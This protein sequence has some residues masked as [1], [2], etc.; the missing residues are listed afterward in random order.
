MV[1]PAAAAK[2]IKETRLAQVL[3]TLHQQALT[4]PQSLSVTEVTPAV[5]ADSQPQLLAQTPSREQVDQLQEQLQNLE[6]T[7]EFGNIYEGSPAITLSNPSGFG[8]DDFTGFVGFGYQERTRFG[9]KDDGT[10]GVG[11]GLGDAE[12]A[13]G[14]QLSYT[15]AS[16]GGSRDFGAGGFNAKLH[17]QLPGGWGIALGWEGFLTTGEVDFEDSIY[18]SVTNILKTREDIRNPFSRVAFTAGVGSGR[19]RSENDIINDDDG[20]GVFGGVAVRVIQPVS[21]IVEWTGQDLAAAVSVVPFRNIPIVITP[22]VRDITG[23]GDGARFVLGAGV[24]FKF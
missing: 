14:L 2:V 11:I 5:R 6:P 9:N 24:S 1:D 3:D 17:R 18:G 12:E 23:A 20:V 8:A 13:V 21:A 15:V 22:G 19:F 10:L 4:T 16:F 7:P